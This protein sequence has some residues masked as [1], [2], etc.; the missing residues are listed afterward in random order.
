MQGWIGWKS[1]S[2]SLCK[3][4]NLATEA[5]TSLLFCLGL[6]QMDLLKSRVF[7]SAFGNFWKHCLFFFLVFILKPILMNQ[8]ASWLCCVKSGG[9][10]K[11]LPLRALALSSGLAVLLPVKYKMWCKFLCIIKL[12]SINYWPMV[13]VYCIFHLLL[14]CI[15]VVT[16]RWVT[17]TQ[18]TTV[19]MHLKPGN[20][21]LMLFQ[22]RCYKPEMK[23]WSTCCQAISLKNFLSPLMVL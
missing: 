22:H 9:L 5:A 7:S 19:I 1:L 16:P 4:S 20:L 6:Q 13:A 21:S 10:C 12:M 14:W 8:L 15:V 11:G 18:L 17:M 3:L 2:P 23:N